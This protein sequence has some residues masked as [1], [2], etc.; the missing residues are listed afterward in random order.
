MCECVCECVAVL[1]GYKTRGK[2]WPISSV[3]VVGVV[4]F[5]SHWICR[6]AVIFCIRGFNSDLLPV[7]FPFFLFLFFFISFFFSSFLPPSTSFSSV[8]S[9][10]S[11]PVRFN[12]LFEQSL[13]AMQIIDSHLLFVAE[14]RGRWS[15]I[16][17]SK[18]GIRWTWTSISHP[19]Q[20]P[21]NRNR[22]TSSWLHRVY[23]LIPACQVTEDAFICPAQPTPIAGAAAAQLADL[24]A[25]PYF[26][27]YW[28]PLWMVRA[29]GIWEINA[30]GQF[31][32]SAVSA[33]LTAHERNCISGITRITTHTLK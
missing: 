13:C 7:L 26:D 29:T 4:S 20:F 10:S 21:S 28:P 17:W 22:F 27:F 19:A 1:Y 25:R 5:A 30:S 32:A 11:S 33:R 2:G 15:P 23:Q 16:Q 12:L 3:A 31:I 8:S 6:G 18:P 14:C 9:S 24:S